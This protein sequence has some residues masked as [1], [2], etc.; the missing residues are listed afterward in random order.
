MPNMIDTG[1][2]DDDQ[3]GRSYVLE[4][5]GVIAGIAFFVGVFFA[6]RTQTAGVVSQREFDLL[7]H[8]QTL[9]EVNDTLGFDGVKQT[10]DTAPGDSAVEG[11]EDATTYVWQNSTVSFVRCEFK[12]GRLVEKEA[13]NL[14]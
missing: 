4:V 8:G 13:T 6:F 12:D 11:K 5:V 7:K 2:A 10:V 9:A 1:P 14:P 3:R